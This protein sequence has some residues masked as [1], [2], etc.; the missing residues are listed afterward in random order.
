MPASGIM[1]MLAIRQNERVRGSAMVE[2]AIVVS[3]LVFLLL[4]AFDFGRIF[5]TA[6][7]VTSFGDAAGIYLSREYFKTEEMPSDVTAEIT[8]KRSV[9]LPSYEKYIGDLTAEVDCLYKCNSADVNFIEL[10]NC[11]GLAG[12]CGGAPDEVR[13]RL[14][15]RGGFQTAVPYPGIPSNNTIQ[16]VAY[17]RIK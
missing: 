3:L 1:T 9:F 8:A 10:N 7:G 4:F 5:V 16:R 11:V 2:F 13:L 14:S 6:M 15:V 12:I 17:F